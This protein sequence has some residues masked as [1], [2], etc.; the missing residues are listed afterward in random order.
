MEG[1]KCPVLEERLQLRISVSISKK[2]TKNV[3]AI[4]SGNLWW[5]YSEINAQ[6]YV[7]K[8]GAS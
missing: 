5:G 1:T 2:G 7:I 3:V 8:I 6:I 4:G